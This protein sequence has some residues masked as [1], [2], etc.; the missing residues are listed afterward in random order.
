MAERSYASV[1]YLCFEL[2]YLFLPLIL[3]PRLQSLHPAPFSH[4]PVL[5]RRARLGV[6]PGS[7][8]LAACLRCDVRFKP[9]DTSPRAVRAAVWSRRRRLRG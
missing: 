7:G 5:A 4:P 3:F 9:L 1:C 2:L 6:F 8:V